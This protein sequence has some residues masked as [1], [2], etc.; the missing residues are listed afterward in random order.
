[1]QAH[2]LLKSFVWEN[3]AELSSSRETAAIDRRWKMEERSSHRL[4][5]SCGRWLTLQTPEPPCDW[6]R[7]TDLW[8]WQTVPVGNYNKRMF[9]WAVST[10]VTVW[11]NSCIQRISV[12]SAA[13]WWCLQCL[14]LVFHNWRDGISPFVYWAC[15]TQ[16]RPM[17]AN[18][19]LFCVN[20]FRFIVKK[21]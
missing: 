9:P 3:G 4:K 16:G 7:W 10:S 5:R 15:L 1:M 13:C 8:L 12:T 20:N 2:Q 19:N 6:R 21:L 17:P 11:K 18:E 14:F